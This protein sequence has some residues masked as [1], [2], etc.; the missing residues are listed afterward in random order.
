MLGPWAVS[1]AAVTIGEKAL[2]DDAWKT[3]TL[4]R[5]ASDAKRLDG[6][7]VNAGL[8]IAGGTALYRLT[9]SANAAALFERM[10]RA[11]ILVRRFAEEPSWLRWGLP[12]DET[13]WRRLGAALA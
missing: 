10:G 6:L 5:L 13:A 12:A 3:R 7:L 2:A 4:E 9:R 1:G 8:E 11:G